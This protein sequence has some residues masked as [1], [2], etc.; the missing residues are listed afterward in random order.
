MR[1]D[2]VVIREL[3]AEDA[4]LLLDMLLEA[5]GGRRVDS[6]VLRPR[7]GIRFR[8]ADVPELSMAVVRRERGRGIGRQPGSEQ[9]AASR[10][11]TPCCLSSP[12][13]GAAPGE[14]GHRGTSFCRNST[15]TE[16][17]TSLRVRPHASLARF[18]R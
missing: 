10:P 3:T 6:Y 17:Q 2:G 1:G 4:E 14:A 5:A 11:R 12:L 13:I 9:S 15:V 16:S 8:R 7:A 18:C